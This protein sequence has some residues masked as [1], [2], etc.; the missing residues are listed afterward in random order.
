MNENEYENFYSNSPATQ[1]RLVDFTKVLL[2]W[3]EIYTENKFPFPD[4]R[5][6][7]FSYEEIISL[8]K[9]LNKFLDNVIIDIQYSPALWGGPP[10]N[11]V[12]GKAYINL[13]YKPDACSVLSA[14]LKKVTDNLINEQ[15]NEAS[16]AKAVKGK[17]VTLPKFP[18]TEWYKLK[19]DF[20]DERNGLLSDGKETRPFTPESL[21]CEDRRTGKADSSWGFFR[22]IALGNGVSANIPKHKRDA[23]KKQKQ[24][25]TDILRN[26]FQND[27]DPFETDKN[28]VYRAKFTI[29]HKSDNAVE[30]SKYADSKQF[31]DEITEAKG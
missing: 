19:I 21:G 28:G 20:I 9:L 13:K 22:G 5:K 17:R 18:R 3:I 6:G 1:K 14:F 11:R 30:N 31:F 24:K 23:I 26:I 8:S 27:T 7:D 4:N 10:N 25:V 15:T 29:S 16:D 12:E 2:S